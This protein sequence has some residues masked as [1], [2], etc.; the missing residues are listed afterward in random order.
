MIAGFFTF[1]AVFAE[2]RLSFVMSPSA[3]RCHEDCR[4]ET[5]IRDAQLDRVDEGFTILGKAEYLFPFFFIKDS[6]SIPAL[7]A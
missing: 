5:W 6:I 3:P 1:C 2:D 7:G 4:A